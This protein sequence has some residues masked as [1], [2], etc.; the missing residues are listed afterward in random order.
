M[1]GTSLAIVEIF[2]CKL[3]YVSTFFIDVIAGQQN[4]SMNG[5]RVVNRLSQSLFWATWVIT[6][7]I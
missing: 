5:C 2:Y 3:L 7:R 4:K 1:T 6:R